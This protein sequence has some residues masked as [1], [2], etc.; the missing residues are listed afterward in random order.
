[1]KR[2]LVSTMN[3]YRTCFLAPPKMAITQDNFAVSMFI[4]WGAKP[5]QH[6]FQL[7]GVRKGELPQQGSDHRRH[8]HPIEQRVHPTAAH[9]IDVTN[10]VGAE[11]IP[12][13]RVACKTA[14]G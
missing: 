4:G 11:H 10:A 6:R 1:M 7:L 9:S 5:H 14:P 3:A 2:T 13:I 8:V 12:A